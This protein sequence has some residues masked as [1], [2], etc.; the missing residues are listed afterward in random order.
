MTVH[1]FPPTLS[2]IQPEPSA[3]FKGSQRRML[4]ICGRF[5]GLGLRA[6]SLGSQATNRTLRLDVSSD[7]VVRADYRF[8]DE[9]DFDSDGLPDRWEILYFGSLGFGP[10][11]NYRSGRRDE[12]AGTYRQQ[13]PDLSGSPPRILLLHVESGRLRCVW[14]TLPG[15]VYQLQIRQLAPLGAILNGRTPGAPMVAPG[16]VMN[17]DAATD[18]RT[19]GV[20]PGRGQ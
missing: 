5:T 13:N 18:E 10:Q 2:D 19:D 14:S 9:P 7:V 11:D 12:P 20:H 8:I 1:G 4:G 15:R 3:G 6:M 17:L 16:N